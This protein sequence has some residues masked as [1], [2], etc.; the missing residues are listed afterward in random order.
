M[1]EAEGAATVGS[2]TVDR[3]ARTGGEDEADEDDDDEDD[4]DDVDEVD[5]GAM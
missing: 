5:D 4:E 1:A 2:T 3:E